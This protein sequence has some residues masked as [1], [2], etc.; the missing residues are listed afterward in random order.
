MKLLLR[1]ALVGWGVADGSSPSA[2]YSAPHSEPYSTSQPSRTVYVPYFVPAE[3][4]LPPPPPPVPS[5]PAPPPPCSLTIFGSDLLCEWWGYDSSIEELEH[6]SDAQR[7]QHRHQM[8]AY[9][10]Y[11]FVL[12]LIVVIMLV[13]ACCTG[14]IPYP[15]T[16]MQ[17]FYT[18]H[19]PTKVPSAAD[20]ESEHDD[21]NRRK[22]VHGNGY[23]YTPP[24]NHGHNHGHNHYSYHYNNRNPA[25][26]HSLNGKASAV[27][28]MERIAQVIHTDSK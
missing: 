15:T 14:C 20:D 3:H 28:P 16:V 17:R 18:V 27:T 24:H 1:L 19:A 26:H 12:A 22:V 9:Y 23:H 2:P 8:V 21:D 25:R 7:I 11:Y 4:P 6:M 10:A 5:P 13:S